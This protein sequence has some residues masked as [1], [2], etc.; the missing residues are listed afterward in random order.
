[1]KKSKYV[2]LVLLTAVISAC[3]Q[4]Q[5]KEPVVYMRSDSTANYARMHHFGGGYGFYSVFRPYGIY[6]FGAYRR[7]GYYSNG[8]PDQANY[9][10]NSYKGTISR[11]GFGSSSFH[12]SS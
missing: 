11:G 6:S 10:F 3:S 12:V 2:K 8:I 5:V 7:A 1:M 4:K 9:G